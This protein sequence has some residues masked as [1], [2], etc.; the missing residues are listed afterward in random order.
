MYIV[1]SLLLS[2]EYYYYYHNIY[3]YV[4]I[5]IVNFYNIIIIIIMKVPKS[6]KLCQY[7]N[8]IIVMIR[9]YLVLAGTVLT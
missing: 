3:M 1:I 4:C 6:T 5:S 9:L 8:N 7:G 2:V